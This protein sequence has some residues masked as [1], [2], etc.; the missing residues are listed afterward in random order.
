ME[1]NNPESRTRFKTVIECD[2]NRL[3]EREDPDCTRQDLP[4]VEGNEQR[5]RTKDNSGV[6]KVNARRA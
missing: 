3:T 2:S 5:R 6:S 4:G 1:T